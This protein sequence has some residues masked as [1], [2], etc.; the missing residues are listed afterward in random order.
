LEARYDVVRLPF[1][2]L[3][4]Y[5]THNSDT[6]WYCPPAVGDIEAISAK[7][8]YTAVCPMAQAR[9]PQKSSAVPPSVRTNAR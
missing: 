8:A 9:K 5:D 7:L 6:Q 1:I 4:D 3:C 2:D